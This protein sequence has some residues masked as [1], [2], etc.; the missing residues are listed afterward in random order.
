MDVQK[1]AHVS[2]GHPIVDRN[3]HETTDYHALTTASQACD[4][5]DNSS[6]FTMNRRRLLCASGALGVASTAMATSGAASS[7][8]LHPGWSGARVIEERETQFGRIAVLEKGRIRYL[9][10]GADT[11]FVYQ[12]AVN[13]DRPRELAAPYMRL[14][15]L[16][17]VYAKPYA[18]IVQV[19]VGAGNMTGY[20][21]R[22]FPDATVHAIDIDRDVLELGGR[23]FGLS[24]HPRL[25]VHLDDG[26]RWLEKSKGVFDVIM[27]DAYD[28]TSIPSPLKGADFFR[29]VAARLAPGGAL[30]QN[31]FKPQVDQLQLRAAIGESFDQIDVY[32]VGQNDVL[33]AY[34]GPRKP[35]EE[36]R[37]RA[38]SLDESLRPPHSL[39][40]QLKARV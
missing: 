9:A 5:S 3:A 28:E 31:V 29:L 11:Q 40:E 38:R 10:Y 20:A 25:H 2:T 24:P 36:L 14:M 33:A 32:R 35:A 26:R 34:R 13:L 18:R 1:A 12:S 8:T 19:G 21:I 30:M 27:L 23:Y 37:Q 15:M 22:T 39:E 16:G 6:S 7:R 17:V 4:V